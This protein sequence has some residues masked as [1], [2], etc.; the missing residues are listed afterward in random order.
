MIIRG[1]D[2]PVDVEEE[3]NEFEWEQATWSHEKLIA[4]SPFR[5]DNRPSF[6]CWLYDSDRAPAG[7]WGDSGGIEF[8]KGNFIT[9]LSYLRDETK[10]EIEEYLLEKYGPIESPG[11]GDFYLRPLRYVSEQRTN[12]ITLSP[13][14][15]QGIEPHP[16]LVNRG[17]PREIQAALN[18]GYSKEKNAIAIPWF[19]PNGEIATIKYRRIDSK[20]FWYEKGSTATRQLLY[21]I[22]IFHKK[23]YLDTA[24]ITEAEIDSMTAMTAGF[25]SLATGGTSW[26]KEKQNLILQT[27]IKNLI[28]ATD[29]DEAGE[30]LKRD[31][32]EG[33]GS[34][35]NLFDVSFPYGCKDLNEVGNAETI[36]RASRKFNQLLLSL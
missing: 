20:F 8:E 32:I 5:D 22:D 7:A 27:N 10:E 29:N 14:L 33:L 30:K 16:Y 4:C 11:N 18:I 36:L 3:L 12:K 35:L 1:L 15:L 6:Y 25:P 31:I 24:V 9:L 19:H 23:P 17:I 26:T 34:A 21:G 2:I 28:I 13:A